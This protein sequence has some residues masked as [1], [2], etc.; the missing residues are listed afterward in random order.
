M[1]RSSKWTSILFVLWMILLT[2]GAAIPLAAQVTTLHTFD[3]AD[4][5][6]TQA[7]LVLTTSGDFYGVTG[8]GGASG[9]GTVFNMTPTGVLTT[10]HSFN[11]TDGSAPLG[12]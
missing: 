3:G 9:L 7:A 11:G 5:S 6:N 4:G 12:E 2:A 1:S 10:V 8:N